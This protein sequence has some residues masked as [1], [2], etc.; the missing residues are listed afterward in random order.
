MGN[1]TNRDV[2][3]LI[4]MGETVLLRWESSF[5]F[6]CGLEV[7]RCM[8]KTFGPVRRGIL[9]RRSAGQLQQETEMAPHQGK[10]AE[11]VQFDWKSCR[12]KIVGDRVQIQK[13]VSTGTPLYWVI[14]FEDYINITAKHVIINWGRA[15][16]SADNLPPYQNFY[17][18]SESSWNYCGSRRT[19]QNI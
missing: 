13:P 1:Y 15:P 5:V 11:S 9:V 3:R 16:D 8:N 2:T 6:Y 4:P 17:S 14:S 10:C 7:H 18:W 19:S 12:G